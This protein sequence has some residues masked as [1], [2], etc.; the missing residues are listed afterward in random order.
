M[1]FV[2]LLTPRTLCNSMQHTTRIAALKEALWPL[3]HKR[4]GQIVK[5]KHFIKHGSQSCNLKTVQTQCITM[6]MHSNQRG[7][8]Q[9]SMS[10]VLELTCLHAHKAPRT[11]WAHPAATAKEMYPMQCPTPIHPLMQHK[12]RS[13]SFLSGHR[14]L[15]VYTEKTAQTQM[16]LFSVGLCIP[17]S[18][19]ANATLSQL[20]HKLEGGR[21]PTKC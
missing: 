2:S 14:N 18:Q 16:A 11:V 6:Q 10:A 21:R 8:L 7:I 20:L 17:G 3:A 12:L 19:T 4:K 1:G 15:K 13:A 5:Q 9:Q